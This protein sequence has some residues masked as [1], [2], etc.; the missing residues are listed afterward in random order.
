MIPN[1]GLPYAHLAILQK[2]P[3]ADEQPKAM[4]EIKKARGAKRGVPAGH[5]Q[6]NG[7]SCIGSLCKTGIGLRSLMNLHRLSQATRG[8]ESVAPPWWRA[9]TE[10]VP[11][12]IASPKS[13]GEL[14]RGA[15][16]E[17]FWEKIS[18]GD[19]ISG[20]IWPLQVSEQKLYLWTTVGNLM[21]FKIHDSIWRLVRLGHWPLIAMFGH[22]WICI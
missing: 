20:Y 8:H 19:R 1:S 15:E 16:Y 12:E 3:A 10:P 7:H 21:E 14:G 4:A 13:N 18:P 5:G 6:W 11:N 9:R 2:K 22:A 17:P